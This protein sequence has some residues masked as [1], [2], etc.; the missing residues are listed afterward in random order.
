[1][2]SRDIPLDPWSCTF[3]ATNLPLPEATDNCGKE[4]NITLVSAVAVTEG[5]KTGIISGLRDSIDGVWTASPSALT[6]DTFRL[7][8]IAEDACHEQLINDTIYYFIA[9][10]DV[11]PP[12]A[13]CVD[14]LN[15]SIGTS[16]ARV[17][18]T[19]I[20]GGSKDACGE[21]ALA[22]RRMPEPGK[23]RDSFEETIDFSCEDTHQQIPV[24]LKVVDPKGN[25]NACW[26]N[27]TIEDKLAPICSNLE[28]QQ[29]AC[30]EV[31][32]ATL[33]VSTDLDGD[34][35]MEDSEWQD[36]G[37]AWNELFGDPLAACIDNAGD[38]Q[39]LVIEQQYQ[40]IP[41]QCGTASAKRRYRAVDWNGEGNPSNWVEQNITVEY[42]PNWSI[43]LPA[44]WAGSC[45][46]QIP[47]PT[48]L[49]IGA[50][51]CDNIAWETSEEVFTTVEGACEKV[52]RSFTIT[53]WCIYSPNQT[54]V[55]IERPVDGGSVRE[56][57]SISSEDFGTAGQLQYTQILEVK[58][59]EAPVVTL[60]EV[61][62]CITGIGSQDGC[63]ERKFFF[64]SATDCME[65]TDHLKYEWT[66]LENGI[67]VESGSGNQFGW[68]VQPKTAS[69]ITYTVKWTV[70]DL[71]G[72]HTVEKMDYDFIDCK[73]P[74]AYALHGINIS[75]MATGMVDIWASDLNLNSFDNCTHEQ[76]LRFGLWHPT[77]SG[78]A[79]TTAEEVLQL[80]GNLIFNCS[81]IGTQEVRLYVIDQDGNW[82]YATTYIIVQ[83]NIGG[84]QGASSD[85]NEVMVSGTIIDWKGNTVEQVDVTSEDISQEVMGQMQ[86]Q[87]QGQYS[88]SLP[89]LQ[90]YSITPSKDI[91]PLNGVSTFDLVLISKHILGINTFQ[92]PYQWIA[93][94][95]NRSG[96]ITAFDMV[97]VRRLILNIETTF[98]NNTAWRFV[99]ADYEFSTQN[100]LTENFPEKGLIQNLH[101]AMQMDFV[102]IKVGD[103]NG[104]AQPNSLQLAEVRS[105]PELFTIETQDQY[106]TEG[107]TVE[108]VF[109]TKQLHAIEGY[110]FTLDFEDLQVNN[111]TGNLMDIE[112]F[113]LHQLDKGFLTA[114]WNHPTNTS[115]DKTVE[116]KTTNLFT[117]QFQAKQ[118][119]KLSDLL[120]IT[121]QPTVA[122][123]YDERGNPLTVALTFTEAIKKE[124]FELYQNQPNPFHKQT[125][126]AFFLPDDSEIALILRDETGRILKTIKDLRA[127]GKNQII[128]KDLPSH[129]GFI[130]YQLNTK[131]GSK[132]MKMIQV[133]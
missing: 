38:C 108:V 117:V 72:N 76:D 133:K 57:F 126:I 87:T 85:E 29:V 73:Q 28:D 9:V 119:G 7:M 82:D 30:N 123:A 49:D 120:Q 69:G 81:H 39:Q 21:V 43:V 19:D 96:T 8:Y 14:Q 115:I 26:V 95:V 97:Q 61:K 122:E 5:L 114:S 94:D 48:N 130:Y 99:E 32:L 83:D 124:A 53:N 33:G 86:T 6:C 113:G 101:Q 51:A 71:C 127:A 62:S 54:P 89:M 45:G 132:T 16:D 58:D 3:D 128:L 50:G 78:S 55:T 74:T 98:S 37:T 84:C 111:L 112:H 4:V 60:R 106:V 93:A 75:L 31:H 27:V 25:E 17:H 23:Q 22:I 12:S 20:D 35:S 52:L 65:D 104:S 109:S 80:D 41:E 107:E 129:K 77:I 118:S 70:S 92:S 18:A 91:N 90:D 131:F 47:D 13:I 46:D 36:L 105:S 116:A 11:T 100:P 59:T 56:S 10:Q 1:M 88:F 125:T 42:V 68:Y 44:D 121:Q 24:E 64:A 102:A 15:I 79:P 34:G 63:D 67:A 66:I 103:V 2:Q 40:L 110:Q